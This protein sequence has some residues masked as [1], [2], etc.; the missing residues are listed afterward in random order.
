[1]DIIGIISLVIGVVSFVASIVFFSLG[2]RTEERNRIIL[3]KINEAIQSWQSQIMSSNIELLNSRVEI[4]GKQVM[5][6]ETKSKHAFIS[7]LS[8]RI[9]FIVENQAQVGLAP[10]Q[11]NLL[12]QILGTFQSA[13]KS[14][15]PPEAIAHIVASN[16]KPS[17]PGGEA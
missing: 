4:V 16:F 9:K 7:E 14:S 2:S 13:T 11:A 3:E 6:E 5:L 12:S 17:M 15:L 10:A 8:E 1:M